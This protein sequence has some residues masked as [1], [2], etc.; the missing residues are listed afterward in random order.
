MAKKIEEPEL[1]LEER[2]ARL[3]EWIKTHDMLNLSVLCRKIPY[4]RGAFA[5]FKDNPT[6]NI[7]PEILR[8]IEKVLGDYGYG[9]T[10][11]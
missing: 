7:S 4:D 2:N 3:R 10:S 5:H 11:H 6:Y 9:A 1:T 8:K